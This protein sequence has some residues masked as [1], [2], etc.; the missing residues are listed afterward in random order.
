MC[1]WGGCVGIWGGV[2]T[3]SPAMVCGGENVWG[4][5]GRVGIWGGVSIISPAISDLKDIK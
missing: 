5:V 3:I 4:G 2:S 1:G